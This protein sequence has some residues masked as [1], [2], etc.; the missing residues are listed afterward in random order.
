MFKRK[1]KGYWNK[2][3]LALLPRFEGGHLY[4][5]ASRMCSMGGF[6]S[7]CVSRGFHL[8]N[9]SNLVTLVS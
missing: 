5:L 6:A 2:A 3:T 7:M 4:G 8:K 1:K 9:L